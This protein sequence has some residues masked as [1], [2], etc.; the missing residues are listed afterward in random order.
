[1][2][3]SKPNSMGRCEIR[4]AL[5]ALVARSAVVGAQWQ[6]LRRRG[7]STIRLPRSVRLA[8][9]MIARRAG[10]NCD[11]LADRA[12]SGLAALDS[13][14]CKAGERAIAACLSRIAFD[15]AADRAAARL[16][17]NSKPGKGHGKN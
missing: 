16:L 15:Q 11:M 6:L 9:V 14:N 10:Q 2:Q 4:E 12:I 8:V 7:L 1:M 5:P 13:G 3:K 17:W